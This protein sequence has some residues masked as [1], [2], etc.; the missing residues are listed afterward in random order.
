MKHSAAPWTPR[1]VIPLSK[2]TVAPG[3]MDVAYGRS[4]RRPA[5]RSLFIVPHRLELFRLLSHG[6]FEEMRYRI[7]ARK[8]PPGVGNGMFCANRLAASEAAPPM[9]IRWFKAKSWASRA[10]G[11]I[12]IIRSGLS[13][14]TCPCTSTSASRSAYLAYRL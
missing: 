2:V 5:P 10:V 7:G 13:A 12:R 11:R 6:A 8:F 4:I 14:L 3:M 1:L 9:R